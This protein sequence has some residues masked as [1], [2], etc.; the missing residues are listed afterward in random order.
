VAQQE[1]PIAEIDQLLRLEPKLTP[2]AK[3]LG[4]RLAVAIASA[5]SGLKPHRRRPLSRRMKLGVRSKGQEHHF[6]I[7]AV[8]RREAQRKTPQ[9][10]PFPHA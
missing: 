5:V 3:Q 10:D 1:Q 9:Q 4:M 2:D 6:E 8:E 7:S